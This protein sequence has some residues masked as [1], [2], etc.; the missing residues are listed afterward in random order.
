MLSILN[1]ITLKNNVDKNFIFHAF[2]YGMLPNRTI[3]KCYYDIFNIEIPDGEK[4]SDIVEYYDTDKHYE[5]NYLK[6][7]NSEEEIICINGSL[8]SKFAQKSVSIEE[9]I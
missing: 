4:L 1:P 9:A 6:M 3:D 5:H 2:S 8:E 7:N